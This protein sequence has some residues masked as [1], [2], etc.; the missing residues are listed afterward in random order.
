M[1]QCKWFAPMKTTFSSGP[2][3]FILSHV[4]NTKATLHTKTAQKIKS[5]FLPIY[6]ITSSLPLPIHPLLLPMPSEKKAASPVEQQ[7]NEK[8]KK[9]KNNKK[10]PTHKAEPCRQTQAVKSLRHSPCQQQP[11][12]QIQRRQL[13]TTLKQ[14]TS[15]SQCTHL[16]A[17]PKTTPVSP[18]LCTKWRQKFTYY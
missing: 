5:P 10:N 6:F 12:F 8:R 11:S 16:N 2:R 9:T 4:A 1:Q 14:P 3:C 13:Q 17:Q 15:P 7:R 18:F